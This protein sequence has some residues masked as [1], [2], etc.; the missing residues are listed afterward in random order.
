MEF[1]L[2]LQIISWTVGIIG[3]SYGIMMRRK[4]I[5][6]QL[7]AE[8]ARASYYTSKRKAEDMKKNKHFVETTKTL[9]D[10]IAGNKS[11][12]SGDMA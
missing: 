6:M 5:R 9:W 4:L 2:I 12:N 11:N 1:T 3:G 10:W 8:R 7:K